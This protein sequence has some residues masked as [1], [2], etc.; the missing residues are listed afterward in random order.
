MKPTDLKASKGQK[1][2]PKQKLKYPVD[3]KAEPPI[4]VEEARAAP[5]AI[6]PAHG[7]YYGGLH[8]QRGEKAGM[9][10]LC[11]HPSCKMYRRYSK[12]PT[13][14]KLRYPPKGFL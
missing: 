13:R 6:C 14:G 7:G 2:A 4:T 3:P 10:Y 9:V 11:L 5:A 8:G 1:E 12:T